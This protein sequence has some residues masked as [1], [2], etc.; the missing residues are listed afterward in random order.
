MEEGTELLARLRVLQR[1]APGAGEEPVHVVGPLQ[2]DVAAH[3]VQVDGREISLTATEFAL[4]RVTPAAVA[5][6]AIQYL[7]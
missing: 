2:M 4:L 5:R 1:R 6:G 3:I 7:R